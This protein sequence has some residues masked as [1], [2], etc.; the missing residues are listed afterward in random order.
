MLLKIHDNVLNGYSVSRTNK[1][2]LLETVYRHSDPHEYTNVLFT[3]VFAYFFE[4]DSFEIGTVLFDIVEV[5][6]ERIV[7][8]NWALFEE[9]RPHGWPGSWATSKD[10]ATTFLGNN[11]IKAFEISSSCGLCGWVLSKTVEQS[12]R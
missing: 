7:D 3:D 2:I 5:S 12:A 4:N 6:P 10:N 11:A 8:N 9:K 1:T